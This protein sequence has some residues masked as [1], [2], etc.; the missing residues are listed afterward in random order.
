MSTRL[1]NVIILAAGKS[2]RMNTDLPKIL[3][4]LGGKPIIQYL[5]DL[6]ISLNIINIY[7]V[8]GHKGNLVKNY[9]VNQPV[10]KL[11]EQPELLGTGHA[12]QQVLPYLNIDDDV[13]IIC[14]DSPLITKE[15]LK[16]LINRKESKGISILTALV[17]NYSE[18][19]KII[20]KNN[21]IV[22]IIE[23]T[24]D[25]YTYTNSTEINVGVY[26]ISVIDLQRWLKLLKNNNLKN[27]YYITDIVFLAHQ[28]KYKINAVCS[29][30]INE[31]MGINNCVQLSE[32]E[33]LYQKKE[34]KKLMLAGVRIVDYN[35]FDLRG[36][37]N[38]GINVTIDVNVII[39]GDVF[40]GDNV[41]I[42]SGCVLKNCIIGNNSV[43]NN[44][45]IICDAVI[46][47]DCIIGPFAHLRQGT[48]L[49]N[50]V[51]IGNFVEIK[52]TNLQP[53]SKAKHLSYLG[54]AD[55]GS[56]VNIG[57]GTIT[58]NYNGVNKCKTIIGN[59]VFIGANTEIV[60]P[61]NISDHATIG[62]GTTLTHDVKKN[63]LVIRRSKQKHILNWKRNIK[64]NN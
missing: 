2:S 6:V 35:R 13:L 37:L 43:I 26:V 62:A 3:Q 51:C 30:N 1:N 63:E 42:H 10:V 5:I 54:D 17:F 61:I 14:G 50:N 44:N 60:A 11:I 46:A 23:N 49:N 41:Y 8:Y 47:S 25:I 4:P 45:S 57:A 12:V 31:F 64:K 27:E 52:N 55:I 38:H 18:Y 29:E 36:T 53:H 56:N 21:N 15:T 28:E 59:H 34:A 7:V 58:C 39:E 32:V 19:G 40:L 20:R 48:N 16:K 22:Q 9:F 24:D 33:R